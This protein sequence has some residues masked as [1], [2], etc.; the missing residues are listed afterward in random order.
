VAYL[1][2]NP[3]DLIVLDMIMPKGM[4]GLETYE[5][6]LKDYPKQKAIIASGFSETEDVKA[7]QRMGA[8]KYIKKPYTMEKLGTVI[9]EELDTD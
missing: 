3:V 6:I 5:A 4:S 1:K 8:G 9:R 2:E 7:T